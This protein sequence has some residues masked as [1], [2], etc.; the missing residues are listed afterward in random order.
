[1]TPWKS[2]S[3]CWVLG[4]QVTGSSWK[5]TAAGQKEADQRRPAPSAACV[6]QVAS[7]TWLPDWLRLNPRWCGHNGSAWGCESALIHW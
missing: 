6:K 5:V 4:E 2:S 7:S 1:M 3:C